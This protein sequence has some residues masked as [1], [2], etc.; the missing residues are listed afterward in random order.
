ML[1]KTASENFFSTV[2]IDA[3][4]PLD[5]P[6]TPNLFASTLGC[7]SNTLYAT[8]AS[9]SPALIETLPWF[10]YV[11]FE[12]LPVKLSISKIPILF[13]KS[14]FLKLSRHD[15]VGLLNSLGP[16]LLWIVTTTGRFSPSLG[17]INLPE[18]ST[19][20]FLYDPSIMVNGIPGL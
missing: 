10:E 2:I 11:F 1:P 4:P 17:K 9:I 14:S 18:I 5:R 3:F 16:A 8:N 13:F 12:P 7:L 6:V 20:E 15:S 19:G